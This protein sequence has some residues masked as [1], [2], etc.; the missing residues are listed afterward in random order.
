MGVPRRT[1]R[2]TAR[3]AVIAIVVAVVGGVLAVGS[4]ASQRFLSSSFGPNPGGHGR[5][6]ALAARQRFRADQ[7]AGARTS[8]ALRGFTLS[9]CSDFSGRAV[10]RGWFKFDGVPGGDPSGFFTR[11]HVS[12]AHGRLLIMVASRGKDASKWASGGICHCG[13]PRLYG[14]YFVRSRVT[15]AGPDEIDLLWPVAH[16]WPPEIDFNE[17]QA[18]TTTTTW[19]VHFDGHN[20]VVHGGTHVNLLRWHT[21]GVI[22]APDS[23]RFLIDGREWGAVTRRGAIPHQPMTLD[24]QNQTFCG[25]GTECPTRPVTMQVDWVAEF[26]YHRPAR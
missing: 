13:L 3:L 24:I 2:G 23:I 14:A 7:A 5:S 8:H 15:G 21:F 19:S 20:D 12:V 22:W 17:S 25:R 16:V 10:P 6:P 4:G 1:G 11:S 18:H 9:Y 26:A